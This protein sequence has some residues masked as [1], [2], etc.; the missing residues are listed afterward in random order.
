MLEIVPTLDMSRIII[1]KIPGA[2]LKASQVIDGVMFEPTFSYA[3]A[4]Q[5]AKS[6]NN[7]KILILDHEVYFSFC[8]S[9]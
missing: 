1:E 2:E 6:F 3:G 8:F 7:P 5:F 9:C 4:D